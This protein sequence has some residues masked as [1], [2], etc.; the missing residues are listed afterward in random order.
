MSVFFKYVLYYMLVYVHIYEYGLIGV[1]KHT[2]IRLKY[3]YTYLFAAALD[4]RILYI[5]VYTYYM[6]V[7]VLFDNC[8]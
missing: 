1:Y 6:R 3:I 2:Y 8:L 4:V 5:C 7:Y